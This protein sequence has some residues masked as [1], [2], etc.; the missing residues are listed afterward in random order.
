MSDA[1]TAVGTVRSTASTAIAHLS[2]ALTALLVVGFL[3]GWSAFW[4]AVAR[5]HYAQGDL[6]S[7][8]FVTGLFVVAVL[9]AAVAYA[10][11]R[12]DVDVSVPGIGGSATGS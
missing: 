4:L 2:S 11:R 9:G 12:I 3:T 8:A 7:A 1:R 10:A 5:L 6:V